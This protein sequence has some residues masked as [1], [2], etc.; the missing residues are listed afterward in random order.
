[1]LSEHVTVETGDTKLSRRFSSAVQGHLRSVEK[2]EAK[3]CP[4][5][6]KAESAHLRMIDLNLFRVFDAMMLHRSV[7]KASQILSVTPSAVSHAL[8]RL[9]QSIGDEL[10]IPTESG[11][12]PTQRALQLASGVREGLEKLERA[13]TRKDAVPAEALRTFR[14]GATDYPCMVVLPS[15]VKRLAKSAPKVDLRVFPS[16]H[17]E[18]VQQLEKGRAD[19]VIGSFTEL[20]AGIRRRRLLRE[21]EVIT[22]RTGH[23]LTRGRMTKERLLEFPQVV[24]EPAGTRESTTDGFS[25]E[26]TNAKRVSVERAL[27]EFQ[28]GR[29]VPGGRAAVCVPNFA[30]V[31]P[32]LQL[33]DMV[34]MLPRR[35]ALRAAAHAPLALVDP[36]YG[37]ITIEIEMLWI[38]GTDQDEG[39]QWLLNE[40]ADS[41]G[42]LG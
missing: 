14:V 20:P 6:I 13:L 3:K 12:Q 1:M 8:S 23:P 32:F 4:N 30:A 38:G 5:F 25:D 36:P 40:L 22:V 2:D 7:R 16:N 9:R 41:I 29:I 19:L 42:D 28:N 10:F 15:L 27:Y 39:L 24:V 37:S 11:M 34:A 21:D 17:I 26:A 18:L 33:S 35:L 31:A